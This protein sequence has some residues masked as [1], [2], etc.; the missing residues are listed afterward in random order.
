LADIGELHRLGNVPPQE[1]GGQPGEILLTV[2]DKVPAAASLRLSGQSVIGCQPGG[3]GAGCSAAVLC[4]HV[5]PRLLAGRWR[6]VLFL[7]TGA[8]MSQTTYLQ[9]ESIPGIAH[10]VELAA[11]DTPAK[12]A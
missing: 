7:S 3:S 2:A 6:R 11:P 4:A 1:N 5:L 10:A 12:E 9:G 8:L